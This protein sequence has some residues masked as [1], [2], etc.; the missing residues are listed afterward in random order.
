[1]KIRKDFLPVLKPHG[2]KEEIEAITEV[3]NSGWWGK[4]PK[5]EEFEKLF[6][7]DTGELG[8]P[9]GEYIL[10]LLG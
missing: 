6:F 8:T 4:G 10:L 1:M 7:T 3:I 9:T 2:G 5:V